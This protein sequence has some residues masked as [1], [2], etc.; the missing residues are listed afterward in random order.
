MT[1]HQSD[2]QVSPNI[3]EVLQR[4]QQEWTKADMVSSVLVSEVLVTLTGTSGIDAVIPLGA[5][6]IDVV[7]ICSGANTSGTMQLKTGADTP[8]AI[9]DAIV[10]AVDK[11]VNRSGTID[12]AYKYVGADGVKVFSNADDDSGYVY[13]LY[14][15]NL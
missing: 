3:A 15:R 4:L 9:T 5:E 12:D 11:V 7:V 10:C 13:I 2:S 6:I 1:I 14:K 8:V